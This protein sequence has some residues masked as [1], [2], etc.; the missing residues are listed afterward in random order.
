MRKTHVPLL[1]LA[2]M[3]GLALAGCDGAQDAPGNTVEMRDMNVLE[4]TV[5]DSMTDLD[6]VKADGLGAV[7]NAGS[8]SRKQTSEPAA[9]AS[10][11][12]TETVA[13]E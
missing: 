2:A 5:N 9:N 6:A 13:S 3:G 10:S 7:G 12:D 8:V 4:G 11:E 1:L